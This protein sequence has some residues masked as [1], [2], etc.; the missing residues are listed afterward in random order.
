MTHKI[1]Q[2]RVLMLGKYTPFGNFCDE[3]TKAKSEVRDLSLTYLINVCE[4][5]TL[6][7]LLAEVR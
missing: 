6:L 1:P 5:R 7:A 3:E 2:N 4:W